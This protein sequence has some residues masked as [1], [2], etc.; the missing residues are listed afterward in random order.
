MPSID[1]CFSPSY[2]ALMPPSKARPRRRLLAV[3]L[4]T[5]AE[6]GEHGRS[7]HLPRKPRLSVTHFPQ[8]IVQ[9]SQFQIPV[10]RFIVQRLQV[11]V[12]SVVAARRLGGARIQ[13]MAIPIASRAASCWYRS[14]RSSMDVGEDCKESTYCVQ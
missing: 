6:G 13:A 5:N 4:D 14:I 7:R 8:V 2:L 11:I 9:S 1:G 12:H 3:L 10:F